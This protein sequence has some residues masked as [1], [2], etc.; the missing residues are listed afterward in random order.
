MLITPLF[1]S[2]I[3]Q[4]GRGHTET[5]ISAA[6]RSIGLPDAELCRVELDRLGNHL[7]SGKVPGTFN[8]GGGQTGTFK[9]PI[10]PIDADLLEASAALL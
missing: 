8:A 10:T 7:A 2:G 5:R 6:G 1:P 4:H 9:P 3:H